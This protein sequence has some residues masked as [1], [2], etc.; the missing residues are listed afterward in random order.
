MKI[1][2]I[3]SPFLPL[4]E[5]FIYNYISSLKRYEPVIISETQINDNIFPVKNIIV[6]RSKDFYF[7]NLLRHT[8]NWLYG[9]IQKE[10]F[11]KKFYTNALNTA[12]SD[13][14]HIHFGAPAILY[15]KIVEKLKLPLIVSFYGYDLSS[16][17][18]TLGKDI[19]MKN[20]LFDIGQIFTAEGEY[21]LNKL[22]NL[23]CPKE[24]VRL[25]RI[26]IKTKNYKFLPR[27]LSTSKNIKLLFCGRFVPK[28]GLLL[29]LKLISLARNDGLNIFCNVIGFGP[30][31]KEAKDFVQKHNIQQHV[32]FLGILSQN[33][34]IKEC[35]NNHIFVAPSQKDVSNNE[36]E[37]GAPTVILE[38]LAT[39]MPVIGSDHA[40]I[41][42]IVID[43]KT[44]IIF[45]EKDLNS[46]YQALVEMLEMYKYWEVM[47]RAGRGFI[48]KY[49]DTN[50]VNNLLEN[51][52]D[53]AQRISL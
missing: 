47:G 11:F 15:S 13:V 48:E 32:N 24:K 29:L 36:T 44:G 12:N 10:I 50:K 31:E 4:T 22:V 9:K 41:P 49:H 37:G 40:D 35:Y 26:G 18:Y 8:R 39:G 5:T 17:P 16:L 34:F 38:A 43:K 33:D 46:F 30:Q 27:S 2:H 53:E 6:Q 28:K 3:K 42:N 14:V 23:G 52:Y 21:A 45:K 20:N 19:Y 25:L 51:Y 1:A 7:E